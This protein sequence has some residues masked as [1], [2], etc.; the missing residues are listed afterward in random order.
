MGRRKH[1]IIAAVEIE[2]SND[3]VCQVSRLLESPDR[4]Y[5]ARS[6]AP[7]L[8]TKLYPSAGGLRS[9]GRR[10]LWVNSCCPSPVGWHMLL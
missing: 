3:R 10:R 9:V 8:T 5:V 7:D 1:A 4:D 2:V 6:R